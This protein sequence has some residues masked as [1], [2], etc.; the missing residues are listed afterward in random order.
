M[1]AN[2]KRFYSRQSVKFTLYGSFVTIL[3]LAILNWTQFLQPLELFIY[4]FNFKIRSPEATDDRI[5]IV[6]WDEENIE[7][8]QETIISD[9]TITMLLKKIIEQKPREIGLD[10]YREI[11][12]SSPQLSDEENL[13]YSKELQKLF[14]TTDNIFAIEK[15]IEPIINSPVILK[16]K[17]QVAASDTP[18]DE[19]RIVRRAYIYPT[20]N[21]EGKAAGLPYLGA[22]LAYEYLAHE[23]FSAEAFGPKAL[24]IFKEHTEV[25]LKPLESFI[26]RSIYD[27]YSFSVF[28][29]WR[30]AEFRSISVIEVLNNRVPANYFTDKI[31]LI[32]STATSTADHHLIPLNRWNDSVIYGIEIQAQVTSSIISAALDHRMLINPVAKLI[33]FFLTVASTGFILYTVYRRR[34]LRS[35]NLYFSSFASAFI[36]SI[37][38]LFTSL[39]SMKAGYWLPTATSIGN[40]WVLSYATNYYL[41]KLNEKKR[42]A[43]LKAFIEDFNHGLG[44]RLSSINSSRNTINIFVREI[45]ELLITLNNSNKSQVEQ[46]LNTI[47]KRAENIKNQVARVIDYQERIRNFVDFGYLN[48]LNNLESIDVNQFVAQVVEQFITR[49]KYEYP[50]SLQQ[51]YDRKLDKALIDRSAWT[52]VLENLLDNA[53]YA[54]APTNHDENRTSTIKIESQLKNNSI[55]IIVEDNGVGIPLANRQRIFLPFVSFKSGS[56]QGVGLYL[57]QSIAQIHNGSI[58]VESQE[59]RGSK[60]I[61][62]IPHSR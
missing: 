47:D 55:Q 28:V 33:E 54:V 16:Q 38:L 8:F 18:V 49:S 25:I 4:D 27:K 22:R 41:Y 24:R 12:V 23:K 45:K 32:G 58:K 35:I 9:R 14:T 52:I 46:K 51:K 29:N 31:V 17:D 42:T 30:K 44:N 34:N 20:T 19:D 61:F 57:V 56:G 37:I 36:V 5:V 7:A 10:L 6:N 53:F 40:I 13:K 48:K 50:V 2:L 60:F 15:V 39:I 43:L 11:P 1:I 59:G 26:G 21:E 3:T 62:T